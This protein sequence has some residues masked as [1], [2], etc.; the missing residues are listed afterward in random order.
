MALAAVFKAGWNIP[1]KNKLFH[2]NGTQF[3]ALLIPLKINYIVYWI[4]IIE[5][6]SSCF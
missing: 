1:S 2:K 4:M 3:A 5:T 6:A